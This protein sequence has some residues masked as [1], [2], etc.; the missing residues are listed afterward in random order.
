MMWPFLSFGRRERAIGGWALRRGR[1]WRLPFSC[2]ELLD[3]LGIGLF[4]EVFFS[5]WSFCSDASEVV[6]VLALFSIA[7]IVEVVHVRSIEIVKE[8]ALEKVA[9][10][11][12]VVK[13]RNLLTL[14]WRQGKEV[15]QE[16]RKE[17]PLCAPTFRIGSY[18]NV[19]GLT[20]SE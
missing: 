16:R 3:G 11:C 12:L 9:S 5:P 2:H 6:S 15:A 7:V 17:K 20:C 10:A 18:R 14:R 1:F 19:A 13:G 4:G 8:C